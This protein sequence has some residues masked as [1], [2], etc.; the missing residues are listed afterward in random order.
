MS[1]ALLTSARGWLV[2]LAVTLALCVMASAYPALRR[3]QTLWGVLCSMVAIGAV[4]ED[5]PPQ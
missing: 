4:R 1:H 5:R 2:I 3:H